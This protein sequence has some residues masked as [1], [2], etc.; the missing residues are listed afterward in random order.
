MKCVICKHG[1]T[2][3]GLTTST[4]TNDALT[5]VVRNVPAHVC[6]ADV[7]EDIASRVLIAA[8]DAAQAGDQVAVRE[9]VII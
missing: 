8:D 7:D 6:E 9:Y 4:L 3:P 1:D 5:L 2:R